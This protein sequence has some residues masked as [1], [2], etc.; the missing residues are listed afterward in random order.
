MKSEKIELKIKPLSKE[1]IKISIDRLT[2][3]K[4]TEEK[5]LRVFK[6]LITSN[7]IYPKFKKKELELM[8]YCELTRIVEE[9]FDYSIQEFD[10]KKSENFTININLLNYE[11]TLFNFDKEVEKLVDN[12]IDYKTLADIVEFE[13]TCLK[14]PI[15]KLILAE[16]I[17][18]E[19]LLPKFANVLG[20][21]FQKEG[22]NLI[23]AGGKNQVVRLFYKYANTLK[24]PM[25]VLLDKDGLDNYEEIK[26]KLR[27]YD[28]VH[29]LKSG[30]FEDLLSLN[31]I[32]RT[33]N[34]RFKNFSSVAIDDLRQ[35]EPMTKILD[36]LFKSK[37]F[38]FKKAEFASLVAQNIKDEKDITQELKTL[39]LSCLAA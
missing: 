17:T 6:D 7:L 8:D 21:D 9:I 38:E 4:Q 1:Q 13:F 16:G 28:N 10:A 11:K 5:Y 37:G 30:E 27:P 25:F 2:R 23:S 22:I 12:K 29:V 24:I 26:P 39:L 33:V 14:Y 15:K 31:L 32:K 18:E 3:F 20:F 19:I 35:D 34:E 36:E